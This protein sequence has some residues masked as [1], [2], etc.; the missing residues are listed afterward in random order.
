MQ[1]NGRSS[2]FDDDDLNIKFDFRKPEKRDQKDLN[3][4]PTA[5]DNL[6]KQSP[7]SSSSQPGYYALHNRTLAFYKSSS[8]K[9]PEAVL[10]VAHS[11]FK[12]LTPSGSNTNHGFAVTKNSNTYEF[13]ST[14]KGVIDNWTEALR[15]VCVLTT[16]H[17][18]YKA[19]KMIGRGSF[20]KVYLVEAKGG[21]KMFAVKAF[22]KESI[23]VSN[24]NNAKPSMINEIDIMR[25]L[26]HENVIKLYEVYETDKSIYLVLELIQGKSLQDILKKSTFREEFS[27]IKVIN[28]IRS[29]LDALAYLAAK[30][31]MHRDLKPDNIL[32]DKGDKIKIVD[33]GLATFIDVPEYIFKKCGTPGY[34]A[35]EVFKYDQKSPSTNY[36]DHCDTFSAGCILFYMLFG[37]PFFEGSNASEIL[38]LNRKFTSEFDAIATVKAEIKSNSSKINKD[39]LNLCLQL[40]EF[41]QK[42]RI[43]SAQSLNHPYFVPIPSEMH[44]IAGSNEAV[45]DALSRYNQNGSYS[46]KTGT[47]KKNPEE[48][49]KQ[50]KTISPDVSSHNNS[51]TSSIQKMDRFAEKDSLYLDM[52]RPELNGKIDT[53]TNGSQNNSLLLQRDPSSNANLNS[54][55]LSAFAKGAQN[56]KKLQQAKSFKAGGGSSFYKAALLKNNQNYEDSKEDPGPPRQ[57]LIPRENNRRYSENLGKGRTKSPSPDQDSE[58]TPYENPQVENNVDKIKSGTPDKHPSKMLS[59]SNRRF[60]PFGQK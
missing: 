38:K 41:D 13:Y 55:S 48:L 29:I 1:D 21:S 17:E 26:D 12:A 19:L 16:F 54:G 39:G 8:S 47:P 14:D 56:D 2:F 36:D 23:I 57:E 25:A 32:L 52:G 5:K 59:S 9:T 28:M 31:I 51:N 45:S 42:K 58:E 50:L 10:D 6:I 46:P 33:F 27:E 49:L 3:L 7:G 43:T 53:L 11:R 37:Y 24:K 15:Y 30:G 20:A 34:I 4:P 18:E 35:P 40:L 60:T 22:T 44:K